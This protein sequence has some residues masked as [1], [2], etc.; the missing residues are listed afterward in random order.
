MIAMLAFLFAVYLYV[1]YMIVPQYNRIDALQKEI[2]K[3]RSI[4]SQLVNKK[5]LLKNLNNEMADTKGKIAAI[6]KQIP[7]HVT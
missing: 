6:E 5:E 1:N 7:S 2:D 4:A 3:K